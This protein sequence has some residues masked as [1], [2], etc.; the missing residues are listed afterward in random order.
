MHCQ[1]SD[2]VIIFPYFDFC[3][4]VFSLQISR[5]KTYI[6]LLRSQPFS[7]LPPRSAPPA[8]LSSSS[9]AQ[10]SS[11]A[12]VPKFASSHSSSTLSRS[13]SA[14]NQ[15]PK[16]TSSSSSSLSKS[17]SSVKSPSSDGRKSPEGNSSS[18]KSI[19]R[20][21]NSN[22]GGSHSDPAAEESQSF[23]RDSTNKVHRSFSDRYSYRMAIHNS[24]KMNE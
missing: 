14:P 20:K 7:S 3:W 4:F 19:L 12:P 13:A 9:V 17:S 2:N 10:R 24:V 16:F 18:S 6:Y 23:L 8:P 5:F 22:A 11:P 21:T 1:V 15:L